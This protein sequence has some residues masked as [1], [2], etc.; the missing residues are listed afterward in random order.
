MKIMFS[1][2]ILKTAIAAAA[3]ALLLS[4]CG[5]KNGASGVPSG[6]TSVQT[7]SY[8]I[9]KLS[10][11]ESKGHTLESSD[12]SLTLTLPSGWEK[13]SSLSQAAVLAVSDR[14]LDK[15]AMVVPVSASKLDDTASLDTAR[16][17]FLANSKVSLQNFN[18][19]ANNDID[20][21]RLAAAQVEFSGIARGV[22]I[23]YLA[24]IVEKDHSYYQIITWST[25]KLFSQ[26]KNE[27]AAII[28]SVNIIKGNSAVAA[29]PTLGSAI[30]NV[31]LV[32]TGDKRAG[33]T[34]PEGW[35][36]DSGLTAGADIQA[37]H[38][39]TEDY[40]VV[41]QEDRSDFSQNTTI[42][43]YYALVSSN[44]KKSMKNPAQDKPR[45]ITVGGL[46]ALQ[47]VLTGEVGRVKVSYLVTLVASENHFTQ[48]LLWT[49]ADEMNAKLQN[50]LY[51]A[52]TYREL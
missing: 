29:A 7:A 31:T 44:M 8:A 15:Y 38:P 3:A 39:S 16:K 35:T 28:G 2:F 13:D 18:L 34:I 33:I 17:W 27:F 30:S 26:Y 9:S 24:A 25:E 43:D 41:L 10:A 51:I 40:M 1:R 4:G 49:R 6:K 21:G 12:G 22:N 19:I 52:N 50:Y 45:Q 42:S 20:I 14:A 46:N 32:T 11:N 5:G 48:V 36:S 47:Y 37:S 23:H